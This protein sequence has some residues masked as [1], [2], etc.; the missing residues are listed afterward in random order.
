MNWTSNQ[1]IIHMKKSS[2]PDCARNLVLNRRGTTSQHSEE[3]NN[4]KSTSTEL[5][6][7]FFKYWNTIPRKIS[8]K[9]QC[10]G[11]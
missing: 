9:R 1:Q 2:F 3:N 6:E 5:Q 4:K 11:F 10:Y 8:L 7:V